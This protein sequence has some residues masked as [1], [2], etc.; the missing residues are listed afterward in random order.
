VA[1]GSGLN[2][3][4]QVLL[5]KKYI[6]NLNKSLRQ[7]IPTLMDDFEGVKTLIEEVTADVIE[8]ARELELQMEPEDVIEIQSHEKSLKEK[9]LLMDEQKFF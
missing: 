7:L 2:F 8:I 3:I 5:F 9:F 1:H 6:T 4:F